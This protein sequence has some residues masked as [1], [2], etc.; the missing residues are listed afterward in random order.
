MF[1]FCMWHEISI[2]IYFCFAC[3]WIKGVFFFLI[4][5]IVFYKNEKIRLN[6]SLLD[7]PNFDSVVLSIMIQFRK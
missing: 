5:K 1:L 2:Y 3:L 6:L 7:E 4:Q